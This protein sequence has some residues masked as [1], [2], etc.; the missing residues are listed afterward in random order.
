VI[1]FAIDSNEPN[2]AEHLRRGGRAAFVR[3][4]SVILAGGDKEIT[5]VGLD[6]VKP[7]RDGRVAFQVENVLAAAASAWAMGIESRTIADALASFDP[8]AG[9]F[10]VLEHV[11][12]TVIVDHARNPSAL[13]A[14]ARAL[15]AFPP[16]RRTMVYA[17]SGDRRDADIV[18]QGTILGD[19]FD[20]VILYEDS[21]IY[22]RGEGETLALLRRGVDQSRRVAETV[23]A[24]GESAAIDLALDRPGPGE[25]IVIGSESIEDTL[26]Y[27]RTKLAARTRPTE[28]GN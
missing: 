25:V 8:E 19:G 3:D 11:G 26:A 4:G 27:V 23:E 18:R 20:R 15:G 2:M 10:H 1:Y 24:Q 14:L 9:R 17:A 6:R 28:D 21:T 12:A 22:D 7:T 16:G 13:D 5:L